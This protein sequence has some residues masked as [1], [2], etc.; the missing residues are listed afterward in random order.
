ME[1]P[2]SYS[3]NPMAAI[4]D[5]NRARE[6]LAVL[7][8]HGFGQI[9][10]VL[11]QGD[12]P[13]AKIVAS[14]TPKMEGENGL[15]PTLPERAKLVLQDLGPTFIKLGQILST[16]PDL[17]PPAFIEELKKLQD[18]VPP[19]SRAEARAQI[20]TELGKPVGELFA[21]FDEDPL[22][23]AS[24]GQVYGATLPD[25]TEVVVKVQ[26]PGVQR[27]I[28]SDIDLMYLLAGMV[29]KRFP[30][31]RAFDPVGI[32]Y[33]FHKA[34]RK[35]LDYGNELRNSQKFTDALKSCPEASVP[36][37]FRG[38][39]TKRILTMERIRGV[40]ITKAV[41]VG[42]NPT[43]LA[44]LALRA[45]FMMV[46]ESGFFH[47][48]PHPGNIFAVSGNRIVFLD[49]GMVGRLD[50]RM[51]FKIADLILALIQ[52]DVEDIARALLSIGIRQG[53][54]DHAQFHSDIIEVL[55]K[56]IGVPIREIQF[57]E[58]V[59]D[60]L[61]GARRNHLKIPNEYTLMGKALLT[62]EGLAKDLDPNL[63]IEEEISPYV[64]NL[65]V[66]RY[67]PKAVLK[68]LVKRGIELYHWSNMIPEHVMTILEDLQGGDLKVK[69]EQTGQ[70]QFLGNIEKIVDKL[71]AGFVIC[72]LLLSSAVF[73]STAHLE[74]TVLGIPVTFFLGLVG[75]GA[76]AILAL[77]LIRAAVKPQDPL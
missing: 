75:Y 58:I 3:F 10:T 33:E 60:L 76:A 59:K 74:Y 62:A 46:F 15:P 65:V 39:S 25:G 7:A 24:I 16:R 19:F 42:S 50:E 70:H 21:K 20:E 56:I 57:A 45:V 34:I 44:R 4:K 28:E 51:R 17:I 32:V 61:D 1:N 26:R 77:R 8:K 14:I 68:K 41:E 55:D 71:T 37:V 38:F 27:I 23:V 31:V 63:D 22:G 29:A 43:V 48:D 67:S 54:I 6:I 64:R 40:K 36:K 13:F 35:E 30:Q 18:N 9:V 73:I 66:I 5:L 2:V 53:K 49:L 47:A 69:V 11:S 12:S 72:A 52:H